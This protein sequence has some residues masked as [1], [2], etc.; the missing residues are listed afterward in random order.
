M[1]KKNTCQPSEDIF[2]TIKQNTFF[3]KTKAEK[4]HCQQTCDTRN[5]QRIWYQN[6]PDRNVTQNKEMKSSRNGNKGK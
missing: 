5:A 2:Q 3:R 6:I 4:I 1:I